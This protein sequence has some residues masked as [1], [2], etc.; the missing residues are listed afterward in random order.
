MSLWVLK[1]NQEVVSGRDKQGPFKPLVTITGVSSLESNPLVIDHL[2]GTEV[3][4]HNTNE[5]RPPP[6]FLWVNFW[7]V[8]WL[9]Q[10]LLS[11]KLGSLPTDFSLRCAELPHSE[12]HSTLRNCDWFLCNSYSNSEIKMSVPAVYQRRLLLSSFV[13]ANAERLFS[14]QLRKISVPLFC[15]LQYLLGGKGGI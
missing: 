13:Q 10:G 9:A 4:P 6:P 5:A 7:E 15:P 8:R 14:L 3:L 2:L 12:R 11:I 1:G